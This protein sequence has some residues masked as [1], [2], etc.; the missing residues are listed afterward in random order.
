V[1][2]LQKWKYLLVNVILKAPFVDENG[3]KLAHNQLN[4]AIKSIS[5]AFVHDTKIGIVDVEQF[6]KNNG[7]N[8]KTCKVNNQKDCGCG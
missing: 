5:P 4:Q 1:F 8:H 6:N 7:D 2:N 3:K